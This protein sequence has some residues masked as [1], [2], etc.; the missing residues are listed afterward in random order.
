MRQLQLRNR[1]RLRAIRTDTLRE[2]ALE[3]LENY[4]KIDSYML[5]IHLVSA[6][7]MAAMNQRFL[8]HRGSTDVIT[9]DYR[10]GYD[11][12]NI[13]TSELAGE[14]YVSVPDAV[15]QA[16]DFKATWQEELV[17][18]IVHGVLHLRGYDDLLPAKRKIMKREENRLLQKLARTFPLKAIAA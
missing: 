5:A 3:L 15:A 14:I 7:A 18:Y 4:L 6:E 10:E 16:K 1:Q 13:A 8:Q 17:R 2:I 12:A 9:F 11:L